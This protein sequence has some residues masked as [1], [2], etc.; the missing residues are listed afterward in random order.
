M[1]KKKEINFQIKSK[2]SE[3]NI[4][5]EKEE[6]NKIYQKKRTKLKVNLSSSLKF[7][8]KKK[9]HKNDK[10]NINNKN[11]TTSTLKN[12]LIQSLLLNNLKKYDSNPISNKAMIITNL[13]ECKPTHYLAVFKDYLINDYVEEFF[14]RIY[15]F[16]ESIDR[17]PNLFNYYKNYL[18]FFCKPTFKEYFFNIIVKNY[19]DLQAEN[20]YKNNIEKIN[21][22][23]NQII[24][25]EEN[26]NAYNREFSNNDQNEVFIKTIFTKSIKNSIDNINDEDYKKYNNKNNDLILDNKQESTIIFDNNNK[27]SEGNTLLLM[28]NEMKE[29][30]KQKTNQKNINMKKNINNRNKK[31][32]SIESTF[33]SNNNVNN[34]RKTF[35]NYN[36]NKINTYSNI[37][38][39]DSIKNQKNWINLKLKK[40]TVKKIK[41]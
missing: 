33:V 29:K 17:I 35:N 26:D 36:K 41:Y 39:V 32:F 12:S 14:K 4:K 28:I 9:S 38:Y 27:V 25:I 20:F 18:N 40:Q 6:Q 37:K 5:I 31:I 8:Q 13:I 34:N 11:Q 15:Y 24:E 3:K 19:S 10:K 23:K 21:Q 16:N 30:H 1:I 2:I 22:D 7:I